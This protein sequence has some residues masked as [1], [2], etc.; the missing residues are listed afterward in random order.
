VAFVAGDAADEAAAI[1]R[2][3]D[4]ASQAAVIGRVGEKGDMPLVEMLT[5][6]GGRRIVQMPYGEDLPRI[7]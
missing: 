2:R 7:C 3:F 4:I 1:L 6:A 5:G